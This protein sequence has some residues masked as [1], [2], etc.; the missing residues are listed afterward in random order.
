MEIAR[1][2]QD[3]GIIAPDEQIRIPVPA[4]FFFAG[5]ADGNGGGEEGRA[6]QAGRSAEC[7]SSDQRAGG[8]EALPADGT[9]NGRGISGGKLC[10]CC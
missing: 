5:A 9:F 4:F 7:A 6:A 1:R 8:S 2:L 3:E 10:V